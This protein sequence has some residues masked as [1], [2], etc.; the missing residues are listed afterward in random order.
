MCV[1]NDITRIRRGRRNHAANKGVL[2][3]VR[4]IKG[5]VSVEVA[6]QQGSRYIKFPDSVESYKAELLK[7]T[8]K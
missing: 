1:K 8:L 5:G 3:G 4:I 6:F 2:V 7:N